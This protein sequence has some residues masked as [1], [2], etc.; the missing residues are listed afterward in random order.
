MLNSAEQCFFEKA[1]QVLL[2]STFCSKCYR[3]GARAG[4]GAGAPFGGD[5]AHLGRSGADAA[6]STWEQ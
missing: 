3:R 4:V 6:A 2:R 5:G 1:F